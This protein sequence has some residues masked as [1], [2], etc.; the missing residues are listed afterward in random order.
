MLPNIIIIHIKGGIAMST[1]EL[2]YSLIDK[3]DEK[4]L[5]AIVVILSGMSGVNLVE[6]VEPDEWDMEMIKRAEAENDGETIPIE[7]LTRNLGLD[8]G[9]L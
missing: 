3:L 7:E 9:S 5:D 6:E 2:A 1:K 4:Q 8:Y